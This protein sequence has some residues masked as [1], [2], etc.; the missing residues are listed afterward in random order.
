MVVY[1]V[2]TNPSQ[3]PV[4]GAQ[5]SIQVDDASGKTIHLALVYTDKDG[6]YSDQFKM[7]ENVNGG[8]RVY[9]SAVKTGFERAIAQSEFTSIPEFSTLT[10]VFVVGTT[11][12]S[13]MSRKIS[14]LPS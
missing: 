4:E 13:L 2:V 7:P 5:V 6:Y 11:L 12:A 3:Q 10:F 8:F 14:K 9:V 1:G